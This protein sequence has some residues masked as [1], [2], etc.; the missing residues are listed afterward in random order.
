MYYA[1]FRIKDASGKSYQ[2]WVSI[3]LP[4][5][6]GNKRKAEEEARRIVQEYEAQQV[7]SYPE[8][9]FADWIG[10]WLEQKAR[11][12]DVVTHRGYASYYVTSIKPW[13]QE[14]PKPLEK[15]T[16]QDIQDYYNAKA[17]TLSG[18]SL[19]KHHAVIHGALKDAVRKQYLPYNPAD[20]VA[21]PKLEKYQGSYLTPEQANRLLEA[22]KGTT[23]EGIV[24]MT[25]FYGLRR[26]EVC[27]L[28]WSA[29]NFE[30]E[31]FAIQSTVVDC[32]GIIEKDTTKNSS[33]C[34]SYP[35][36]SEIKALLLS[37]RAKQAENRAIF[38]NCYHQNEYVFTWEDGRLMLPDY[39]TKRFKR[40]LKDNGLPQIR[41]HDLRHT[42]A[43]LLISKGW[44][45]KRISEWLGHGDIS[46]TAN[47]YAHLGFET[48]KDTAKA[49]SELL[50][51]Q[52]E[53]C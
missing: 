42:T 31:T 24:T 17:A 12:V 21:L 10:M 6:K 33:S 48:K 41:F 18:S 52:V 2:K 39:V 30:N 16:V 34:R 7:V 5:K 26:S 1:V 50:K 45:M 15:I 11:E 49:M 53:S 8:L 20:N 9:S 35:M 46:T 43:S 47:I 4:V 51:L 25:V 13:F 28:K 44:D 38:G 27:G 29:I 40:I 22:V 32:H 23:M 19:R 3:K 36:T 37:I 14:H